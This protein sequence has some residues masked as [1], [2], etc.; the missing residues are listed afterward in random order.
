MLKDRRALLE[1]EL[2]QAHDQASAMYLDIVTQDGDVAS[3]EY[4]ALKEKI[5]SLQFDLNVVNK[6][7][8]KG[9]Q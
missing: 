3:V 4:Q 7:I 8:Y 6:L 5:V 2:N 1:H 9:H